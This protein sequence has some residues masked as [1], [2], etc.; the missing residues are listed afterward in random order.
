MA[1]ERPQMLLVAKSYQE[2]MPSPDSV[3]RGFA[4]TG[5]IF[6]VSATFPRDIQ[7]EGQFRRRCELAFTLLSANG[8]TSQESCK[9]TEG[10]CTSIHI[11]PAKSFCLWCLGFGAYSHIFIFRR[12]LFSLPK[13]G[14]SQ[15]FPSASSDTLIKERKLVTP[16][17]AG[18][19][20]Q[21][22][23]SV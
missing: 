13:H 9:V 7:L 17:P 12:G 2:K 22:S 21:G 19:I 20:P 23:I 1:V 6:T 15:G 14:P 11:L 5:I 3:L 4:P 10:S 16:D 18:R 8:S